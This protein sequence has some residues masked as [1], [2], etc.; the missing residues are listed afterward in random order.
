ML[1]KISRQLWNV[2]VSNTFLL[3][4]DSLLWLQFW[5]PLICPTHQLPVTPF[6]CRLTIWFSGQLVFLDVALQ[7]WLISWV[8]ITKPNV[9]K[10]WIATVYFRVWRR[11]DHFFTQDSLIHWQS[12]WHQ[13][14]PCPWAKSILSC[15]S[16]AKVGKTYI[17]KQLYPSWLC[18]HLWTTFAK[19][20]IVVA[21]AYRWI[22]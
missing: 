12:P 18:H 3:S 9:V 11:W 13:A 14:S 17:K 1:T 2:D 5:L 20:C 21:T 10:S 7:L 19:W 15:D 4:V 16:F 6:I 22:R 8:L